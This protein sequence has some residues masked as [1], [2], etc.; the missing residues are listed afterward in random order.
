[1][2]R[3]AA[4]STAGPTNVLICTAH[5]TES[6]M[7]MAAPSITFY[8][9]SIFL[10]RILKQY[11]EGI[12]PK[13]LLRWSADLVTNTSAGNKVDGGD[14]ELQDGEGLEKLDTVHMKLVE[15]DSHKGRNCRGVNKLER[16]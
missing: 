2:D 6:W 9:S 10:L 11:K 5:L 16:F 7:A 4:A 3:T 15:T 1:M 12:P 14:K 13:C 8:F